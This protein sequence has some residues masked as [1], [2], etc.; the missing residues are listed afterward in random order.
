MTTSTLPRRAWRRVPLALVLGAIAA[1]VVG[2]LLLG[3]GVSW[4]ASD[5]MSPTFHR[6]DLVL[7]RLVDAAALQVGDVPVIVPPGESGSYVHRV[8]A[9][10]SSAG[11]PVLRTRGDANGANDAWSAQLT[12][13]QVPLVIAV[14]PGLG[15]LALLAQEPQTRALLIALIGLLVTALAVREVLLPPATVPPAWLTTPTPEGSS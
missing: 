4:V 6:G 15:R 12:T 7:T 5:S 11:A 2:R 3:F 8:V 13:P 14:A 1:C 10:D 9:L